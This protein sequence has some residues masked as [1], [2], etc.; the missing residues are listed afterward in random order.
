MRW[1]KLRF[2]TKFFFHR[3]TKQQDFSIYLKTCYPTLMW[4]GHILK[5]LR[6]I[7]QR[8]RIAPQKALWFLMVNLSDQFKAPLWYAFAF[9][10]RLLA[11][12]QLS[13]KITVSVAI[14]LVPKNT[15]APWWSWEGIF[16][17]PF[18]LRAVC[19]FSTSLSTH[20]AFCLVKYHLQG[21]FTAFKS[22]FFSE[23]SFWE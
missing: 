21:S 9:P 14:A 8:F 4:W 13:V 10:C 20:W 5:M 15:C 1:E 11:F 3:Q 18:L 16:S 19:Y 23:K 12:N 6:K 17:K 2:F 7:C 22:P